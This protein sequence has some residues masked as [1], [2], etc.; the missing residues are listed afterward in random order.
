MLR[1]STQPKLT[2]AVL[3]LSIAALL[4]GI[5][6]LT[7]HRENNTRDSQ[8]L[9]LAAPQ[10]QEPGAPALKSA[11]PFS[12]AVH[13]EAATLPADM[14]HKIA[15]GTK[16]AYA[17]WR[18]WLGEEALLHAQIN[19]RFLGDD[20]QFRQIYGKPSSEE[21]T[22]TGFYRV[23]SNEALI[24]YT[25]AYRPAALGSAFHEIS[26]LFTAA[27]LGATPPWLN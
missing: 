15:R 3:A 12:I 4:A 13:A 5:A 14:E 21:W 22:T 17:Q 1:V 9:A 19:I 11:V 26:H 24:L 16:A 7:R 10:C 2:I 6:T 20:E 8:R 23:R 25:A 27:H 18:D